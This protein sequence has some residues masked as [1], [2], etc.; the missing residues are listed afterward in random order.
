MRKLG[1]LIGNIKRTIIAK[2][3]TGST[4]NLSVDRR[5]NSTKIPNP[6]KAWS[7]SIYEIENETN[8]LI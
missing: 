5:M 7:K 2:L 6:N 3:I 4:I 1:I 8:N